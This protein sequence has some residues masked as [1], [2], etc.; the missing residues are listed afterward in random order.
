MTTQPTDSSER[1]RALMRKQTALVSHTMSPPTAAPVPQPALPPK[2]IANPREEPIPSSSIPE[3]L[4][5]SW[6]RVTIRLKVGEL[7]KI[8]NIVIATQ[9]TTRWSKVT[10]TDV[11]RV[12]LRRVKDNEAIDAKELKALRARDRRLTKERGV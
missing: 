10:T 3:D 2:A 12:A 5:A 11:L 8:N 7:E 9:Q 6:D 1:L 4:R